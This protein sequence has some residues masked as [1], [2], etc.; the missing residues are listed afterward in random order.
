V[1]RARAVRL[2]IRCSVVHLCS[3][4]ACPAVTWG[5]APNLV[6]I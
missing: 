4:V 6:V 1:K 2:C 5:S 3:V